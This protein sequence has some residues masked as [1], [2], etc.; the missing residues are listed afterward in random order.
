MA[1]RVKMK[2][3]IADDNL[4]EEE[5]RQ[6]IE[7]I[8]SHKKTTIVVGLP[9]L[10]IT[11]YPN[12]SVQ[13]RNIMLKKLAARENVAFVDVVSLQQKEVPDLTCSYSWKHT[14][15]IRIIDGLVMLVFP[16]SK[17]WS[18]KFRRLELTVDGVHL[19]HALQR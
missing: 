6:L 5:Y 10:Q 4:F 13:E 17:D 1:P 12:E 2:K 11:G 18:S 7:L 15:L 3:C 19:I 14:N 16:F 8:L 9:L